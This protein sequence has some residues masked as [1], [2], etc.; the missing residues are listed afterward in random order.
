MECFLHAISFYLSHY[1]AVFMDLSLAFL[2]GVL[3]WGLYKFRQKAILF[4]EA[5]SRIEQKLKL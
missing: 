3:F 2:V 1:V 4:E 5:I